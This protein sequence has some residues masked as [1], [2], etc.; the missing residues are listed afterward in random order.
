MLEV[1]LL[2]TFSIKCDGNPVTLSSRAAQSL[3]AYLIL[4]AGTAHRREKLAGMF[5]LD[6]SEEKARAH[7]RHELWRIRKA[8]APHSKVNYLFADDINITF[9]SSA[10]Y[11][12]DTAILRNVSDA[13]P[14]E[15]LIE[16]L[17]LVQGEFLPGFYDKWVTQ[18]REHLQS[19]HEQ[20]LAQLLESLENE[21]RWNDVLDWAERW[22]SFGQGPE[23]AYRYLMVVYD[24]LGE[25]AKVTSTFQRC[26]RALRELDL[27]PSEQTRALAFKRSSKLNIPIP[28]TSFVGREKEL[29]EVAKLL[30]KSRLLTLT[31]AGGVGKTRLAIQVVADVMEMFS[32]GVWFLDLAPL[33][34]PSLVPST[35]I[36]LLG[37]QESGERS[38]TDLL[39][40][41]F[42]SRTAL[43][44]FDNCE[45]LIESCAQLIHSLLLSCEGLTILAT[46]RE[47]LR[48]SGE[49]PYRVPSLAIP[50]SD[51]Q[52]TVND[53]ANMESI[54]LFTERAAV[55]SPDFTFN[56]QN[57]LDIARICERLDGIPLAI[58]LAAARTD[59]LSVQQIQKGLDDRFHLL[60]R[61]M[62]SSLPR[63]QTLRA[64]IKW[65]HDLLSEKE[66]ILYRRLAVFM[67]GW[68][69]EAAKE[70]CSGNSIEA[71]DILDLLSQLVNKSLILVEWKQ[72][73]E[74]RYR[75]LETIRQYAGDRLLESDE[76][77]KLRQQHLTYFLKVAEQAEGG[78]RGA[79]KKGWMERL[80]VEHDNLRVALEWSLERNSAGLE[81]GLRVAGALFEFWY[82][83]GHYHEGREW[84]ERVFAKVSL[85]NAH[86]TK[87]TRAK[88]LY[89]LGVIFW[90][91]SNYH[92]AWTHAETCLTLHQELKD[93]A[94]IAHALSLLGLTA[95]AQRDYARAIPLLEQSLAISRQLGDKQAICYRLHDLAL[96]WWRH[97][98]Y[99]RAERFLDESLTFS[100]ELGDTGSMAEIKA[101]LA[102]VAREQGNYHRAHTLF[103]E[104]LSVFEEL[105]NKYWIAGTLQDLGILS[106]RQGDYRQAEK[107]LE[108]SLELFHKIGAQRAAAR[109]LSVLGDVVLSQGDLKGAR[110][111][112]EQV[113]NITEALG[114]KLDKSR[115]RQSLA[116]I[117]FVEGDYATAQGL[118]EKSLARFREIHSKV[119]V[120]SSLLNLGNIEWV[121]GNLDVARDFYGKSLRIRYELGN[122]H[123]IAASLE[124]IAALATEHGQFARA[125]RLF[126]A[127]AQMR[128]ATG[129]PLEPIARA[130]YERDMAAIKAKLSGE[131]FAEEW[132]LGRTL[133]LEQAIDFALEKNDRL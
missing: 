93:E 90:F 38:V 74:T 119:D 113:A 44:I 81:S 115:A 82:R 116:N 76:R 71:S 55:I 16:A 18:E 7:L 112:Y 77:E 6:A 57:A 132:A 49:I 102:A 84:L 59:V 101:G 43:I 4:N 45:H 122:P 58:E 20:K 70:V 63:H 78:L 118:Y 126:A 100:F 1:R 94:G 60:T 33:S 89:A 85:T 83:R 97:G 121:C 46:S 41:Y 131:K 28:L 128:E 29:E 2:G 17:S 114:D 53:L 125:A 14:I 66:R 11:W 31:G 3:F 61:G 123:D 79:A 15:E 99:K 36:N 27:E 104:S 64:M 48:V 129:A 9:N 87:R 47:A 111:L 52:C 50:S 10:E 42:R 124:R 25:H 133:N 92:Q 35:L 21:K 22:I 95:R 72:G 109:S 24:A 88:A 40:G 69:L 107:Q 23:A 80:E 39:T 103:R 110:S 73:Q 117:A 13:A 130:D 5:W 51:V 12:V 37:L 86:I 106:W 34:D 127:A 8:F 62:R 30:L 75:M 56:S 68:T 98:E 105:G 54:R 32:D 91:L 19:V 108:A 67:G 120:A 65:S 96:V 26:V